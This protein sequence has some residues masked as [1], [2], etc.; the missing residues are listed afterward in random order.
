MSSS[1]GAPSRDTVNDRRRAREERGLAPAAQ[2]GDRLPPP[3]RERRPALA[4]LAVLLIVGGAALAGLL[5]LRAD[6]RVDVLVVAR[7]VPAG[8]QLT[9]EDLTSTPVASE[10]TILVPAASK[11]AVVGQYTRVALTKKQLLDASMI[12]ETPWIP[13]G[14]VAVGAAIGAGRMPANGLFAGDLVQLVAVGDA[15]TGGAGSVIVDQARVSSTRTSDSG[16]MSSSTTFVTFNVSGS[17]AP[18][19]AA[20]AA[21]GDLA[22]VLL[23]R[24]VPLD[25]DS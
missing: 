21:A 8:K 4:A 20:V 12:S 17:D 11:D 22:V 15:A 6:N 19:V 16:G 23:S 7:D 5:A 9:A 24:G 3:P 13:E 2:R 10:G 1:T 14:D 18:D 25:Q